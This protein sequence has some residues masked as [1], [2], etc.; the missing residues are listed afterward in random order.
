MSLYISLKLPPLS[1]VH[2]LL[3]SSKMFYKFVNLF[4]REA[5]RHLC[6]VKVRKMHF[7]VTFLSG[8]VVLFDVFN[9][10]PLW[11]LCQIRFD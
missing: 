8:P 2:T 1:G 11:L 3:V 5:E 7:I 9:L 6:N 4:F 10:I